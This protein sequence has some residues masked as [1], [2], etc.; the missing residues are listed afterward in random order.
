MCEKARVEYTIR[1]KRKIITEILN[2][3]LFCQKKNGRR[4]SLGS[5]KKMEHL[6]NVAHDAA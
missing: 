6:F 2:G 5:Q 3:F 4:M 1:N